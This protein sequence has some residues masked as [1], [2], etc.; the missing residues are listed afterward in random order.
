M[1]TIFM[2]SEKNK[3]SDLHRLSLNLTVKTDLRWKD[4]YIALSNLSIYYTWKNIKSSYNNNKFKISAPTWNDEFE[5]P[6]GSYSV[7]DIQDYFEYIFKMCGEKTVNPAITIYA[8]KIENRI[9][10]KIKTGYYLELLTPETM[11]L[12]GSTKSKITKDKNGENVLYLEITE[13]VLIHCNVVNNSYQQNSRVLYTFVP[14][15]SFGQLL[16]ISPENFIYLKTFDSE[17]SYIEVWFTDQNSNPL[18]IEDKINTTFV[19]N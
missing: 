18:E 1:N 19:I 13:E 6:D 15:K 10:F 7:S 16:D 9:T 4:K 17:F 2:N 3:T 8:N 11:K 5:L 12:L 14:N